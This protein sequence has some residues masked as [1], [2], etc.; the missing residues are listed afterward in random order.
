MPTPP[1]E[2]AGNRATW[3]S[4]TQSHSL[5]RPVLALYKVTFADGE[6]RSLVSSAALVGKC[7]DW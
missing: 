3:Q 6:L 2:R 7:L 1:S 5:E 4:F